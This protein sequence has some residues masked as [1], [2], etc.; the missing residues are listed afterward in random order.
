MQGIT[1]AMGGEARRDLGPVPEVSKDLKKLWE[2]RR[3]L[4]ALAET[5]AS[6]LS[7]PNKVLARIVP[8]LDGLPDDQ[9]APAAFA[10]AGR[11]ARLGQWELAREVYLLVVDRYPTHPLAVDSCRW[12]I[13]HNSSSE[14]RRR[15]ELGQ[16]LV[17]STLEVQSHPRAELPEKETKPAD[18]SVGPRALV[19]EIEFR[20][21]KEKNFLFGNA[22]A[23]QWYEESLQIEPK[24]MTLGPLFANDPSIQFCLQAARR[25]LGQ[26]EEA[27]KWFGQFASKQPPGPWR[28][29]AL[30]ELWL[31]NRTGT[32]PK[33]V[34]SCRLTDTKPYLDGKFD[35]ACWQNAKPLVL[36]N[37]S[38][39]TAEQYP[40]EVKLAY[41]KDF[42]YV[43]IT[44]K[45][46]TD[47]YVAPAKNRQHDADVSS[48][49]H[50]DLL[51]DLDRDYHTCFHLQV[52]QRGCV[53]DACWGDLSWNP[54]WFVALNSTKESWQVEAAIPMLELT[55]DAVTI[56]KTW[57]CNVTRVLPGRGVQGWSLPAD[58]D[59]RLEGMGLLT[60][61]VD[62]QR[63]ASVNKGAEMPR[64]P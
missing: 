62:P 33:P 8:T 37:A 56:G 16:Y 35:D 60:F 3:N 1:L 38:G 14:V 39:T 6:P 4:L 26:V 24:L 21:T 15:Y 45:H 28:D 36:R 9:A 63:A 58:V 40:T 64:V 43:A 54:S 12:L 61:T 22:I 57:A 42:L 29:A 2:T 51:L 7:D 59:P 27:Q 53:R 44:C 55:G 10:V 17:T 46:P 5:P 11:F 48:F 30:A 25:N 32:P 18:F 50:V 20:R 49:D 41:D 31:V 19:P 34:A 23:K 47:K 13:A 52:D